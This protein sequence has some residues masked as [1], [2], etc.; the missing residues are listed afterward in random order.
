MYA[1]G[2]RNTLHKRWQIVTCS[3][4]KY[5]YDS[6]FRVGDDGLLETEHRCPIC[7]HPD[8]EEG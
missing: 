2:S 6:V 8:I 1:G 5:V 7:E 3:S 4:C